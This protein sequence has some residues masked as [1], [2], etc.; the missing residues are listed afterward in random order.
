MSPTNFT[1][2]GIIN[3]PGSALNQVEFLPTART[4]LLP[5]SGVGALNGGCNCQAEHEP[6]YG[7]DSDEQIAPEYDRASAFVHFDYDIGD[8]LNLYLQGLFGNTENSDRR[9]SI[10]ASRPMAGENL[11]Q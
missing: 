1:N 9:E 10:A 8:N 11:Q 4:D 5:F 6:T 7:V 3:E 2:G